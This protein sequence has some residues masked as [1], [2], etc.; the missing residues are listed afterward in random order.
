VI[1]SLADAERALIPSDE[2]RTLGA[3]IDDAVAGAVTVYVRRRERASSDEGSRRLGA[4]AQEMRGELNDAMV[5]FASIRKGLSAPGGSTSAILDRSLMR[6]N[7]LVDRSL[8]DVRLD[9][10]KQNAERVAVWEVIEEV[11]VAASMIARLRGIHFAVSSVDETMIVQADRHILAAAIASLLQNAFSFTHPGRT[12]S[13]SASATA[14]SVL[15]AVEDG[16]GGLSPEQ[17]VT[18]LDSGVDASR[19][20]DGPGLELPMCLRA[21]KAIGGDLRVQ[22]VPGKG[23]VFTVELPKQSPAPTPIRPRRRKTGSVVPTLE[24]KRVRAR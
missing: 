6:L 23:C 17:S 2:T 9:L 16:R 11:E 12:V 18:L 10:G 7:T 1:R 8:A 4:V 15:I 3:C 14:Q 20:R 22:D 19:G 13:L 5:A 24:R 21:M